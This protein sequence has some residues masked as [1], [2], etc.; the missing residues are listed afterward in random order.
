MPDNENLPRPSLSDAIEKLMSDPTLLST[1]ARAL[2]DVKPKMPSEDEGRSEEAQK[3]DSSMAMPD[4]SQLMSILSPMIS[5]PQKERKDTSVTR[6]SDSG[7][8]EREA[9][10]CALK[11]YV[12]NGRKEAI[13]YIIRL[14]KIS[15][16]LRQIESKG[17]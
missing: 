12:S 11:P 4:V 7:R 13:D 8:A 9:L 6:A 2:G 5:K 16:L 14:S 3:N 10:L 15:D 1:V 17:G